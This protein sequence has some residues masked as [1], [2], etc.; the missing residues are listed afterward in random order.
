MCEVKNFRRT[1]DYF[2][3]KSVK[4]HGNEYDYSKVKGFEKYQEK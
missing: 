1:R 2:I 3:Q 4:I